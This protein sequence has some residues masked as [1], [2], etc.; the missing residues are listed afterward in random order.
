MSQ[1]GFAVSVEEQGDG[2]GSHSG[3]FSFVVGPFKDAFIGFAECLSEEG[4]GVRGSSALK[5]ITD[6]LHGHL[7]GDFA[8]TMPPHAIGDDKEASS[9]LGISEL[10]TIV[11][12]QVPDSSDIGP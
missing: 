5:D 3:Q 6:L 1:N 11:L 8:P 10:S 2:R 4:L 7:A 9:I 12:V